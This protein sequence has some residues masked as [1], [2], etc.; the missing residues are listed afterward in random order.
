M[1]QCQ[2]IKQIGQD[3]KTLTSFF[4]SFFTAGTKVL[5]REGRLGTKDM[6]PPIF[7]IFLIFSNFL[8]S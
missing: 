8:R 2:E 6:L 7:K 1:K 5:F 3:E 4:A